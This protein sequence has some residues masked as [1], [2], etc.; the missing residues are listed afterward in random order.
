MLSIVG[1]AVN[2]YMFQVYSQSIFTNV[3]DPVKVNIFKALMSVC[4][5]LSAN[6]QLGLVF[7][8]SPSMFPA[9]DINAISQ[10]FYNPAVGG[11]LLSLIAVEAICSFSGTEVLVIRRSE[12]TV[13]LNQ[14]F[15]LRKESNVC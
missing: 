4:K 8:G 14:Y 13:G 11:I 6:F 9:I 3:A 2:K 7:K 12:L 1:I 15:L 10:L 5:T